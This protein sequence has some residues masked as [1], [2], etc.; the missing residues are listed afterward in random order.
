MLPNERLALII[1]YTAGFILLAVGV[2]S[3]FSTQEF[4]D[5]AISVDGVVVNNQGRNAPMRPVVKF[6]DHT[7]AIRLHYSALSTDPPRFFIGEKV[8]ILYDPND[9]KYPVNAKIDSTM[10]VWGTAIFLSIM[11]SF[12]IMVSTLV[13]YVKT[14]KNGVLFLRKADRVEFR[15]TGK[16]E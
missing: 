15:K 12:F 13:W 9:P 1:T 6:T 14:Y 11:G 4:L 3:Y 16:V 8:N 5:K 2:Y 7:G 10:T